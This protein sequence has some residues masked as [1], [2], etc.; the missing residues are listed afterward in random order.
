MVRLGIDCH[1][2]GKVGIFLSVNPQSK[3][4]QLPQLY[5]LS[6]LCGAESLARLARCGGT[7]STRRSI[8]APSSFA[9]RV[10]PLRISPR[11]RA[12]CG[13]ARGRERPF[14]AWICAA[15][16]FA[17]R[18]FLFREQ[19]VEFAAVC[20]ADYVA[21]LFAAYL[22]S[23]NQRFSERLNTGTCP[24]VLNGLVILGLVTRIAA[25]LLLIDIS[26]AII[27]TKIP[28]LLGH[29]FWGFSLPKL[30]HYGLL[31]MIHEARTDLSMWFSLLFLLIV[32]GG[33][34]WS[35]DAKF[36]PSSDELPRC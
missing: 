8:R 16:S 12:V 21:R 2:R 35:V 32:G 6:C 18:V 29:G 33:R 14:V 28:V 17:S 26:V 27:S 9:K 20:L 23:F 10:R 25:I 34:K 31:S 1:E 3:L 36:A 15:Y 22:S 7:L 13:P 30:P 24:L 4:R 19:A 11:V 5:S